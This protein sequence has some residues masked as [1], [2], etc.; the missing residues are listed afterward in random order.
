MN[1]SFFRAGLL[2]LLLCPTWSSLHAIEIPLPH[3]ELVPWTTVQPEAPGH[4]PAPAPKRERE[5]I[6]EQD[7]NPRRAPFLYDVM[8]ADEDRE[9]QR[10]P[11]PE[12]LDIRGA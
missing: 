9:D 2:A 10:R 1:R 12:A 3:L 5:A 6:R 4:R 8:P 11:M 7:H